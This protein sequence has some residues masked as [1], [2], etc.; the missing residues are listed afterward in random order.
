MDAQKY[1]DMSIELQ[2]HVREV[3][4]KR[5][6]VAEV[7]RQFP[8]CFEDH[9]KR[10]RGLLSIGSYRDGSF[11]DKV[12]ENCAGGGCKV[13]LRMPFEGPDG[14]KVVAEAEMQVE[15]SDDKRIVH[16]KDLTSGKSVQASYGDPIDPKA[17]LPVYGLIGPTLE[18][19]LR[20]TKNRI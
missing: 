13:V 19:S 1:T 9:I 11:V 10:D 7:I 14:L 18:K 16:W 12:Y 17:Y 2:Q 6:L 5:K 15:I 8:L 3:T 20:D 4:I